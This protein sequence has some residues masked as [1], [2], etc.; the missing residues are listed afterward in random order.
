MNFSRFKNL[1]FFS[2]L[3]L[4]SGVFIYIL[5]PFLYPILWAAIIAG[6]F[7][8]M[9]TKIKSKINNANLSSLVTI[10]LIF[11]IIIIP[12]TL[13]S[14]LIV[15]ESVDIYTSLTNNQSSIVN[16]SKDVINWIQNNPIT[17]K[18]NL[19]EQAVTNKLVEIAK[20]VTDFILVGAKNLTQNSLT[21]LIMFIIMFYTLFFFLKDGEKILKR[22]AHLSPLGEKHEIMMYER[23]TSTTRAVLKGSLIVGGV[24]G[25]LSGLLFYFTGIEGALIWGIIT[26]LFAVIPGFG[27][28][29]IWLPAALI[30]FVLGNNIEGLIIL[31]VGTI[32]ISQIDNLIR[33]I[34]VGK[35]TQ[36]HPLLILF[37]TLGG[38]I[39]FGISGFIIGPV[40]AAL[41][42]SLWEM[43]EQHYQQDLNNDTDED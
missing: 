32:V 14:G 4:I 21:F 5:R 15:K 36:M 31:I 11:I 37:S 24:Q 29:V 40:V 41:F 22:L 2:A 19:D 35:D 27:S 38:L 1:T 3:L 6:M 33:P 8:P 43:Y 28:Y 13:L 42:L 7:Y 16:T 12:V 26:M 25:L 20:T 34:L 18:L 30:M 17:D 39:L 23:F 9:Y 10:L